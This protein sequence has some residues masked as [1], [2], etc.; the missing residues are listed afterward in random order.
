[1]SPLS[2]LEAIFDCKACGTLLFAGT[3]IIST[4]IILPDVSTIFAKRTATPTSAQHREWLLNTNPQSDTRHNIPME[5]ETSGLDDQS[6]CSSFDIATFPSQGTSP[7]TAPCVPNAHR[8][9][10]VDFEGRR[11]RGHTCSSVRDSMGSFHFPPPK[12]GDA[13]S[14]QSSRHSCTSTSG[15][16]D[17]ERTST[18][19]INS[20]LKLE[21]A[22]MSDQP[23]VGIPYLKLLVGMTV[24]S[25]PTHA[26][27]S[28]PNNQTCRVIPSS[29]SFC[30]D[31]PDVSDVSSSALFISQSR[32][33]SAE[34]RRW[35]AQMAM[36]GHGAISNSPSQKV[37]SSNSNEML[38]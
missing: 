10:T 22:V 34:K 32:P 5:V 33:Q 35:L 12:S 26:H 4:E 3:S 28:T 21:Q 36:E 8:W 20:P 37:R 2:S 6:D 19:S 31:S 18:A 15:A 23:P 38:R 11:M 17:W 27:P 14:M 7:T 30:S 16:M 9:E 13:D 29:R 1:M 25:S 24:G